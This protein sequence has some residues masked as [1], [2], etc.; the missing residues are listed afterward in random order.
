M[1]VI[2][3]IKNNKNEVEDFQKKMRQLRKEKSYQ[4]QVAI[5]VKAKT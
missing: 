4:K 3:T 5:A 2:A 1:K